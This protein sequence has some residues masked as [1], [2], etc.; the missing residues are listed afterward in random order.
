MKKI[1]SVINLTNL[2]FSIDPPIVPETY[3]SR[4]HPGIESHAYDPAS[5]IISNAYDS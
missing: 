2:N 4:I 1:K 3:K 5:F